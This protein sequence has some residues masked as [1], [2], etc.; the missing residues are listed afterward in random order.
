MHDRQLDA[1]GAPSYSVAAVNRSAG[2]RI[3]SVRRGLRQ[4]AAA[5][6]ATAAALEGPSFDVR[7]GVTTRH[8]FDVQLARTGAAGSNSTRQL[9]YVDDAYDP[10][11]P[12]A[13]GRSDPVH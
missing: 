12:L 11:N 8:S 7:A 3:A 1:T 9:T 4:P 6:A 13:R 5:A 10:R 2:V